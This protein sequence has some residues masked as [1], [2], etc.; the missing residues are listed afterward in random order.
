MSINEKKYEQA[1]AFRPGTIRKLF[2]ESG[3]LI[4][5]GK[6]IHAAMT[7]KRK[8]GK[9]AMTIAANGR[10]EW[11]IEGA[12][13]AAHRANAAIIVEIA[14]SECGYCPVNFTNIARIVNDCIVRNNLKVVVAVHADHYAVKNA[15]DLEKAK[16]EIPKMIENGVTSVAIDASHMAP[17]ENVF[18]NIELAKLLPSWVSLETEVGEIKG[19]EGLS[20]PEEALFHI[21]ALNAHSVFPVWIALNNGSVHGLEATGGNIDVDLTSRVHEAISPYGVC[22]AQHGTSGNNYT[23]L[24]DIVGRTCTTKANVATALQMISWGL[25]VNEFGNAELDAGKNL[26]K[27]PDQ[28]VDEASWKKMVEVAGL[29]GWKTGDYKKLNK[30]VDSLLKAQPDFVQKRMVKAVEDFIYTLLTDVFY[31]EGTGDLALDAILEAGSQDV[32]LFDTIVESSAVWTK[33]YIAREG[34][35]LLDKQHE[36]EGNFDD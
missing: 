7:K 10:N 26:V 12:L 24:R 23:K 32:K 16:T 30:E 25:K 33:E 8:S 5:S 17:H 14:K 13:R 11:V 21:K 20:T 35:I 31:A 3:A 22:G 19:K 6:V 34:Q 18:A 4:V 29:K 1:L 2:P 15:E 36:L 9:P 28:G 27:L